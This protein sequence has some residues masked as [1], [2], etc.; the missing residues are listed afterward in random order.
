MTN[1]QHVLLARQPIYN[2][3]LE[4]HAYELLFRSNNLRDDAQFTCGD[5]A[6]SQ[7]L[8]NAFGELG[9]KS[10]CG[11]H[12][13]YINF[14]K[15]LILEL[16]PFDPSQFVIEILEDIDVDD[17]LINA[18][19]LAKKKGACLALDDFIL[20]HNSAPLLHMVDIVKIDVLALSKKHIERFAKAFIPR[21]ITLLAEKIETH[22]MFDFCKSLGF[23]LFQGYFLSKPQNIEGQAIPENK[24]IILKMLKEVQDTNITASKLA[25]T[26]GQ[27]PQISYK[28]LKLVNS[29]AFTR[30]ETCTSLQQAIALLGLNQ[31]KSWVT[32][33]ALGNMEEKPKA[34]HQNSLERAILCQMLGEKIGEHS[35]YDYYTVG[36]FSLLD[37]YFDRPLL[38]IIKSLNL[39]DYMVKAILNEKG[40]LGLAL[41]T[42]KCFQRGKLDELNIEALEK[43]SL[44]I[45][46]INELYKQC[47][48]ETNSQ[49]D[50]LLN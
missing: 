10:I 38:G 3:K 1:N 11:E 34:L 47:I 41:H 14:T 12:Q 21:G 22:E 9:L 13:A 23:T 39:P 2:S 48:I 43:H 16:P 25:E 36:L 18:L 24:A 32:L 49:S 4:I 30:L 35:I 27:D 42:A 31:L 7:V 6:T 46:L 33:I 5:K 26:I 15:N 28:L 44:D 45:E 8:L 37:A 17:T 19:K 20:N 29:A 40:G 50:D